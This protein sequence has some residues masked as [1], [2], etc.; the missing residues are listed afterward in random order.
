MRVAIVAPSMQQMYGGQEVQGEQLAGGWTGSETVEA[1]LVESNPVLTGVL[2]GAERIRGARTV[3]RI[4]ERL[5]RFSRVLG[6]ADIVHVFSGSH[7]SF[8]LGSLPAILVAWLLRKPVLVHYHSP[9][10][11]SHLEHSSVARWVFRRCAAV[12]VPSQYLQEVFAQHEITS[13]IIPNVVDTSRFKWRPAD[14][15]NNTVLCIRN[16]EQRYG[17]DDVIRAF[18]QVKR[19]VP[20]ATLCLAGAGPEEHNL[21]ALVASLGVSDVTFEGAVSR[22]R[23]ARLMES[24]SVMINASR[25]DNMPLTILEAFACGIPVVT[26]SAG[27]IPTFVSDG[28]NA[29]M[30]EPG[31]VDALAG[32]AQ[33]LLQDRPLA[34]RLTAA[35][36]LDAAMY[37]WD[38]VRPAWE[39]LYGRLMTKHGA[40]QAIRHA[41]S[42]ASAT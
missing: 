41:E 11:N 4:P 22:D 30:T 1:E 7:S 13:H 14:G 40:P 31:N 3:L 21:A 32:H 6:R 42:E 19:V 27:G 17:V 23:L 8:V 33:T 34:A 36:R 37:S 5:R 26:T 29:L 35:A 10:A 20:S 28:R 38:A 15:R 25:E 2:R 18:A 16:F 39:A 24:S 9:F 12:V